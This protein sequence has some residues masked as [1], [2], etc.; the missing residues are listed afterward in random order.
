[1]ITSDLGRR[2]IKSFEKLRLVAYLDAVGIP[3]IGYG[4]IKG[5]RMGM[6]CAE[7][8]ADDWFA[9]ELSEFEQDAAGM[10]KVP[11]SQRQFDALISFAYNCG[12]GAL[13]GSTLLRL[14]NKSDYVSAANQFKAWDKG[15]VGGK[16]VSLPGLTKR[17]LA[18]A[19]IFGFGIYEMHDGPSIDGNA[20]DFSD[21]KAG[22]DTTAKGT[23]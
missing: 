1:M 21:V 13:R 16:L 14:L 10:V 15:T 12:S 17:R 7:E 23:K 2:F 6:A 3:T 19:K 11:I 4:H 5:V 20:T 8:Q 18:E 9:E 22:F